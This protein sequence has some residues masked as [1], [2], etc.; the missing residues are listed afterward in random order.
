M[1]RRSSQLTGAAGEH[2]VA[3]QLSQRGWAVGILPPSAATH[4]LL[5]RRDDQQIAV[6]VKASYGGMAFWLNNPSEG[7]IRAHDDEWFVLVALDEDRCLPTFYVVPA[8]AVYVFAWVGL[9]SAQGHP[10]GR[11][12]IKARDF[13]AYRGGWH[14]L[15]HRATELPFP[16]E[17]G[18]WEWADRVR[19]KSPTVRHGHLPEPDRE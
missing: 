9:A 8:H 6:Q 17:G 1:A 15:H 18:F 13:A 12:N 19:F 11:S 5:A 16:F 10:G 2:Y 3:A 4:D 14:L 7:P